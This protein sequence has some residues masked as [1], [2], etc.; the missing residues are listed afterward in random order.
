MQ[1]SLMMAT[2]SDTTEVLLDG[3]SDIDY[4]V[5]WIVWAMSVAD[6][7]SKTNL[8][9]NS[10]ETKHNYIPHDRLLSNSNSFFFFMFVRHHFL[11]LLPGASKPQIITC[12]MKTIILSHFFNFPMN[13]PLLLR[14]LLLKLNHVLNHIINWLMVSSCS[15][16]VSFSH[17]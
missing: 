5:I 4:Y 16:A 14:T 3:M 9:E 1:Q 11:F 8:I 12:L 10:T 2:I 6:P 17:S 7:T 15:T 13:M